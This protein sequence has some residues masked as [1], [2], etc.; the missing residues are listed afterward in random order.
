V[1][2]W[3]LSCPKGSPPSE[4]LQAQPRYS[5][6]TPIGVGGGSGVS[7]RQTDELTSA[8]FEAKIAALQR[9]LAERDAEIERL[10][11]QLTVCCPWWEQRWHKPH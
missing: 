10:R 2:T 3:T 6:V 4:A 9:E 1:W 11:Q 5:G 7:E 8:E